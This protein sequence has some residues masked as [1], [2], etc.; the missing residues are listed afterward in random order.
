MISIAKSCITVKG[1]A[2]ILIFAVTMGLFAQTPAT[3]YEVKAAYLLNFGKFIK[4]PAAPTSPETNKFTICVMGDDPFGQVLDATVRGEKIAG[5]PVAARRINRTQDAAGCQV[6]F[7]SRSEEKQVRK[8]LP[9]LSKAGLLTVS[10]MPGFLDRDG[11]IQFTLVGNR[12][13][14]E[15]NLDAVQG[16]G[17]TLSSE[18]LKVASSVKGKNMEVRP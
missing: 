13:R 11:M 18:L 7:I 16:A 6:L 2:R 4:E 12:V 14:F 3:E 17:L 8:I 5:K 10:D 15:V 9:A 1:V